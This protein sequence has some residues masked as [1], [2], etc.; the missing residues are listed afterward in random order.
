MNLEGNT[1]FIPGATSGIGLE[2]ATQL[3]TLGNTIIIG[4][5]RADL[6][7]TI[8]ENHPGIHTALI[9]VTDKDSV[10]AAT[11]VVIAAHPNLNVLIA[12][13]GIMRFEDW[14]TPKVLDDAE[15]TITTNVLGPLRLIAGLLEHLLQQPQAAV[16]TVS[17]GLAFAPL[18]LTPT[19]NAS[20]AAIHMLSESLRL[21]L[22]DSAVQVI[23][24]VP[25]AV[26]TSLLPG[27]EQNPQALPPGQFVSEVL[28]L[29]RT[30]PDAH[31]ILV[32]AVNFLRFGEARGDY[33]QVIAALNTH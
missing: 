10:A 25:P 23:E 24:I 6:L 8:A 32:D 29:M 3:Q 28:D 22:A 30:R 14:R 4:G 17:S 16:V 31:E 26:R 18:A 27:Q 33:P 1:I 15:L 2:L 9:D 21:Q 11:A 13:A 5:R 20:K 19:Y 7:A 12:M